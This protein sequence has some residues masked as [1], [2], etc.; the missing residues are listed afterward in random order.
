MKTFRIKARDAA[1]RLVTETR[2][3][4]SGSHLRDELQ[5]EGLLVSSLREQRGSVGEIVARNRVKPASILAM[6]RELRTIIEAGISVIEALGMVKNRPNDLQL[7]TALHDVT[8][9]VRRG[10]ALPDAL[11]NRPDIFEPALATT[12]QIGMSSGGLAAALERYESDLAMRLEL[13]RK[14]RKAMAYPVFLLCL[15]VIVLVV[16]FLFILP[17]FVEL[18]SE[19]G[20]DL[21]ASTQVLI[22]TVETAPLWGGGLLAVMAAIW[23]GRKFAMQTDRGKLWLDRV[24]LQVPIFG[25]LRHEGHMAQ[26]ASGLSLLLYSG[27]PLKSALGLVRDNLPNSYLA[28]KLGEVENGVATGKRFSDLARDNGF[29]PGAGEGLIQAG[30][31]TGALDRMMHHVAK[32]HE[33]ELS[34]RVDVVTSLIEPIMM[35][36]VGGVIGVIVITVYLPIFGV[37]DVIQ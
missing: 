29:F 33:Q 26:I 2:K 25:R 8:E 10:T 21:P 5:K 31:R 15:L 30:E 32:L 22:N 13:A 16:L 19:F 4:L 11:R 20:A 12:F 9:D 7:S 36:L 34:D 1:G 18:Y 37:S 35:V 14:F 3:G 17:N 6:L 28:G 27:M 24:S 23:L